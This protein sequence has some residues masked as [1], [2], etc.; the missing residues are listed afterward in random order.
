MRVNPLNTGAS[1]SKEHPGTGAHFPQLAW[2][3]GQEIFALRLRQSP[4]QPPERLFTFIGAPNPRDLSQTTLRVIDALLIGDLSRSR[5]G[6]RQ[7]PCLGARLRGGQ[8]F[9]Q[10]FPTLDWLQLQRA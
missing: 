2:G 5:L 8:Q 4:P 9:L 3:N 7:I 6:S 1:A 10:G